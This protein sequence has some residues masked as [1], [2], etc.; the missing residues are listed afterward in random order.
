MRAYV[1]YVYTLGTA[2]WWGLHGPT[3]GAARL[4]DAGQSPFKPYVGIGVA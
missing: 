4:A 3:L 2:L 1:P